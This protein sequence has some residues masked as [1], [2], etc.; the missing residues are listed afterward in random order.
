MT[1]HRQTEPWPGRWLLVGIFLALFANAEGGPPRRLEQIT[2]RFA[3]QEATGAATPT[4]TRDLTTLEVRLVFEDGR[5]VPDKAI[6]GEGMT[7]NDERYPVRATNDVIE[8]ART[9]F[10]RVSTS[11]AF[12]L[13]EDA[14]LVLDCRLLHFFVREADQA[15][16]SMYAAD[17][18]LACS[19]K[20]PDG[21]TLFEGT[22]SGDTRRYGKS[23]NENNQNEVLSDAMKECYVHMLDQDG[24]RD[25]RAGKI[26]APV[27]A[28]SMTLDELRQELVNLQDGGL[29][30]ILMIQ[31]LNQK[32][33][34]EQMTAEQLISW[35]QAG[36]PEDVIQAALARWGATP[37]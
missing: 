32:E 21:A 8:F 15:V 10:E 35:K 22:S 6:V 24:L 23:R 1:K 11:W 16:G 25:A 28:G 26:Q 7:D 29:S 36:L 13:S 31:Y 12:T 4:M 37:R 17:V 3:P 18:R 34:S 27:A 14:D 33:C 20:N 5:A 30:S 19:V 9:V 2:L